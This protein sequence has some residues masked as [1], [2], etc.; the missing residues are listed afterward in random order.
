[1][2]KEEQQEISIEVTLALCS[3]H[4]LLK[5]LVGQI[6]LL[7]LL[8]LM[9]DLSQQGELRLMIE[10]ILAASQAELIVDLLLQVERAMTLVDLQDLQIATKDLIQEVLHLLRLEDLA[11]QLL[12]ARVTHHQGAQEALLVAR[13]HILQDRLAALKARAARADQL[14]QGEEEN[15]KHNHKSKRIEF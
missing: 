6:R 10:L 12:V 11:G 3:Q 15:N 1:M 9:K 13:S 2:L 14:L 4:Q 5:V 7:D 8:E